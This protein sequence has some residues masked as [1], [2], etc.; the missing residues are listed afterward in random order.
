LFGNYG[1]LLYFLI[2]KVVMPD[3]SYQDT[4]TAKNVAIMILSAYE[5]LSF[6]TAVFH[7]W[8]MGLPF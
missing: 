3:S 7:G 2:P 8:L 4:S 5:R 6:T 1:P